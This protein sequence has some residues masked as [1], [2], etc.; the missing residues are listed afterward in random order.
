M[1]LETQNSEL[2]RDISLYG[3]IM[4]AAGSSIGSGIFLTPQEIASTLPF[5]RLII[6]AWIIGGIVA[7]TGALTFAELGAKFPKTGGVYVFLRE[8]Y[9]NTVAFMYGWVVLTVMTT[10]S[11]AALGLGFAQYFCKLVGLSPDW[12]VLVGIF[13]ISFL[14]I[15]NAF[16]VK[17]SE[18][19]AASLTTTK[20]IGIAIIIILGLFFIPVEVPVIELWQ[21]KNT[22]NHNLIKGFAIALI[23]VLWSY[24]GWHHAS[25]LAG[26]TKNPQKTVPKAM[27]IGASIVAITYI[28]SNIAYHNLLSVEEIQN[29]ST[30]AADAVSKI[31]AS[32]G[33]FISLLIAISIF[34]TT[35]IFTMS[36]PRIYFAMAKDGIFF[37][38]LAK[39]NPYYKTPINAIVT[40]SIIAMI[41]LLFWQTFSNLITYVVFMDWV[42]MTLGAIS[43]FIFRKKM[44]ESLGYKTWGYPIIPII[45]I[46]ISVAFII[47]T[48]I[49]KPLQTLGGV[50]VLAS[51]FLVF[52]IL[53]QRNQ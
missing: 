45:F 49:F 19:V 52:Y 12:Y 11:L 23:G 27:I 21:P 1:Q 51:G 22:E 33:F 30:V 18:I 41:L 4:I 34:G 8:A 35:S 25:Y 32:G 5:P 26:E 38:S 28:L 3:L 47:T 50:V 43:I 2:K 44:K 40:Q 13:T 16:G 14:T 31:H 42:F 17:I 15:I 20:L 53:K 37:K 9:G 48:S 6:I 46:T 36:A 24:G 7:L 29:S 10:G 39:V